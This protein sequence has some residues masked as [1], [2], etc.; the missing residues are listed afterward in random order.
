MSTH[1]F[2]SRLAEDVQMIILHN[3][4]SQKG[5]CDE[6]EHDRLFGNICQVWQP[7]V[8][9]L[10]GPTKDKCDDSL[11]SLHVDFNGTKASVLALFNEIATNPR[12]YMRSDLL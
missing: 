4:I 12:T 5:D 7:L 6:E 11:R 9:C 3:P 1:K 2:V 10:N 8:D